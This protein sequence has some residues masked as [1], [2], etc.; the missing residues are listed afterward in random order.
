MAAPFFLAVKG[1][2]SGTPGTGAFTPNTAQAGY[3]A[4]STVPT[5]W[6]GLVRYED[7]TAWELTYSYW[8]G[9]T[10]SRASTQM[11]A[12]S[13]GSQLSLSSSGLAGLVLDS[14]EVQPHLGGAQLRGC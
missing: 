14:A 10:L 8:N 11:V 13:T 9:T 1:N 5:G 6:I 4:W 7:G 12:S 2:T 3:R